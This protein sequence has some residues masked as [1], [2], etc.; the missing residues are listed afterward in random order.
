MFKAIALLIPQ[1]NDRI[2]S[3]IKQ[4]SPISSDTLNIQS[5]RPLI[6]QT[7]DRNSSQ[8]KQ[9]SAIHNDSTSDRF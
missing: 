2:S 5:D 6:P 8:I 4:R 9:R 3:Q 1:A 7:N